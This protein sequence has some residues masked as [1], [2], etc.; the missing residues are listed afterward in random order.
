M[1]PLVNWPEFVQAL[2]LGRLE[3][4]RHQREATK[5]GNR[6]AAAA[7]AGEVRDWDELLSDITIAQA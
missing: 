7:W 2:Q 3:A 5:K 4:A 6:K 1:T